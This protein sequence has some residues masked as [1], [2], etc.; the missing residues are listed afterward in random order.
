VTVSDGARE[1]TVGGD[2]FISSIPMNELT[3][4][5][6]PAA[7]SAALHATQ[8]LTYRDLIT[9]NLMIDR[10]QVTH[11]T[12]I[13][14]HDSRMSVARLHH[15]RN[16]SPQMAPAGKTSLVLEL[17]CDAGD[18]MWQRSDEEICELATRELAEELHFIEPREVID[19]VA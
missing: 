11:D 6:D 17:F 16:W 18:G 19:S 8:L 1:R 5:L 15:P 4:I 12:W 10:P 9:V 13:Y 2:A 14:V 7:D 3:R